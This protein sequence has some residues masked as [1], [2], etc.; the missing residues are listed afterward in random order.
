L[1][2]SRLNAAR[3]LYHWPSIDSAGRTKEKEMKY[4]KNLGLFAVTAV[5][6]MGFAGSASAT[7]T[8]PTGTEYTGELDATAESSLLFKAGLEVTC[9]ETTIKASITSNTT[10]HASGPLSALSFSGCNGTVHTLTLGSLTVS[11]DELVLIGSTLTIERFGI[12]CTYS[13]GE[14]TKI[15]TATNNTLNGKD[16]VTLDVNASLPKEAGGAFCGNVLVWSGYYIITT[17]VDNYLD[18]T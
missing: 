14:G 9:T 17:P 5:A 12:S 6:M 10:N 8:S 7:F 13:G 2:T 11:G 3:S 1:R 16:A 15:G 4:L 18:P